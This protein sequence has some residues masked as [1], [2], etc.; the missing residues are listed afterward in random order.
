VLD[1]IAGIDTRSA[2]ARHLARITGS[3]VEGAPLTSRVSYPQWLD[4]PEKIEAAVVEM[5][6]LVRALLTDPD[7][8]GVVLTS[9]DEE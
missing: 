4:T 8:L 9:T 5:R 2:V 1:G 7:S 6:A 3:T